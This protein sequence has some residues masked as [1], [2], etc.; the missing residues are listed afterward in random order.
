[1]FNGKTKSF[2][3][4]VEKVF[5]D[6]GITDSIDKYHCIEQAAEC[7]ELIGAPQSFVYKIASISIE[8]SR[9]VLLC[10]I[11]LVMQARVRNDNAV[12]AM[13]YGTDNFHL[14]NRCDCTD[15]LLFQIHIPTS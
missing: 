15:N 11:H 8:E 3:Y 14:A 7:M 4:I 1:M 13:R 12:M 5:R 9:C 10:D 6:T 2:E